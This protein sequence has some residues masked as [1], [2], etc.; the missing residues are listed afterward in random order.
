DFINPFLTA[1][2]KV[3]KIQ[4]F[5]E[6]KPQK[7]HSKQSSDKYHGDISGVIGLLSDAF[8]GSV[9]ISFPSKTFLQL[10]SRMLKTE[11]TVINKIIEDGAG[12]LTNMIFGQAKTA[13][14]EKGYGVKTALPSVVCGNDHHV[15][16]LSTGPRVAIP[17]NSDAGQFYI[18]ICVTE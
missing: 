17:F 7:P 11:F 4:Y 10:M 16:L 15:E 13:L 3:L 12:E 2:I 1:A 6:A 14:N 8:T 9:V 5:T 18:E